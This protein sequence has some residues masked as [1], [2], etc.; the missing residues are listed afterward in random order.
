MSGLRSPRAAADCKVARLAPPPASSSCLG[1]R[2]LVVIGVR[3]AQVRID[4]AF[5]VPFL[6]PHHL[7]HHGGLAVFGCYLGLALRRTAGTIWRRC[8]ITH[9]HVSPLAGHR[10]HHPARTIIWPGRERGTSF[11]V[12]P[13]EPAEFLIGM[14]GGT[15]GPR[16]GILTW[17]I[18][19]ADQHI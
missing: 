3:V 19:R 4:A 14:R 10:G 13:G 18:V 7:P 17:V 11:V 8:L 2:L 12:A 1:V 15:A 9:S 16:T 6:D 5:P